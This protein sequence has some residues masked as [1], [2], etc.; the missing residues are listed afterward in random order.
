MSEIF[1][2]RR[3]VFQGPLRAQEAHAAI[4]VVADAARRDD[5]AGLGS[6]RRAPADRKA[7]A[8]VRVGHRKRVL[9]YARQGRHV[10]ELF[11]RAVAED[12]LEHFLRCVDARGHAHVGAL[13]RGDLPQ[14]VVDLYE[15]VFGKHQIYMS[16]TSMVSHSPCSFWR[17][18]A[19]WYVTPLMSSPNSPTFAPIS[20]ASRARSVKWRK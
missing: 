8:L 3:D 5:P 18:F 11:E 14:P 4:D 15:I 2:L 19:S 12:L 13:A 17:T 16:K 6:N 10:H 7:V 1:E 20:S 9:L